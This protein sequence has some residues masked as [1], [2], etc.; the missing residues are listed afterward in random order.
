MKSTQGAHRE[1]HLNFEKASVFSKMLQ[2][3]Y[4]VV[5]RFLRDQDIHVSISKNSV[6]EQSLWS[7]DSPR[8][9]ECI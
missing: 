9:Q 4:I 8:E 3:A 7:L 2:F 5:W 6:R 1:H